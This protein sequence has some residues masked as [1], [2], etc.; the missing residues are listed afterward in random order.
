MQPRKQTRWRRNRKF[1]D[2]YGGR[3]R[4]K[5][6]DNIFA[7]LHSLKAPPEDQ[8]LPILMED[9]PSRD[10]YFPLSGKETLE[11]LKALPSRDTEAVTHVWLRRLNGR[12]ARTGARP[13]GSFICG[14]GVR[15]VTMYA[16]PKNRMLALGQT[17]KNP[18]AH[19]S[20]DLIRKKQRWFVQFSETALREFFTFVLYHEIGHHIDWYYRNWSK[21]NRKAV[22]DFAD[23][24]AFQMSE[25]GKVVLDGRKPHGKEES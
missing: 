23:N 15:L 10:F 1:G 8:E 22:E 12:E 25:V 20:T 14:S 19:W 18:Y 24:Y 11:L 17:K 6:A 2:V 16:W 5:L 21:A 13:F 7:R 3:Q 9:N 4:Q